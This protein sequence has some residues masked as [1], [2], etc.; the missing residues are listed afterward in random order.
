M[1]AYFRL[2]PGIRHSCVYCHFKYSFLDYSSH[3]DVEEKVEYFSPLCNKRLL[4]FSSYSL[5]NSENSLSSLIV[6]DKV[7]P[8]RYPDQFCPTRLS[9]RAKIFQSGAHSIDHNLELY[10]LKQ[11]FHV[12]VLKTVHYNFTSPFISNPVHS[13]PH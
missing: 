8:G 11:Y 9:G 13:T 2:K 3:Y 5:P 1:I 12:L 4:C 6:E 7:W 10:L